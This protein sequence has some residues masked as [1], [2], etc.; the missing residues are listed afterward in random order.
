MSNTKKSVKN[1]VYSIIGQIVTITIGFILPRLWVVSY[2]SEVNGLLSSLSQFLVYLGL[3]EAGIG[4]A[5]LHA[6]YKPVAENDWSGIN[7]VLAAS[8][9]YYRQTGRLYFIGLILLSAIYPFVAKS[10]LPY[11]TVFGSVFF[12]GIGNVILFYFQGKYTCLLHAEGKNYIIVNLST[13]ITILNGITKV[14][15]IYLGMDIVVII[16]ST[17]LIQCIQA[18]YIMWYMRRYKKIN[19]R[20]EPNIHSVSQKKSILIHQ[21]STLVFQ[22]TDILILT[23]ACDLKIVSVYSLFKLITTQIQNILN[24][25]INSIRFA[26]GQTFQLNKA[27]FIKH[28]DI[29]E[30]L[31]SAML[32]GLFSVTLYLYLPFM[33]LYTAGVTD[34]NYI[35]PWLAL[36]FVVISLLDKS[37]TSMLST[38]EFAGHFKNTVRQTITESVINLTISLIGVYL[39][40]IYGVLIGT[41]VALSYRT[42]DIIIY[43]NHK[44]LNRS[45]KKTYL[46]YLINILSFLFLQ[47]L[48]NLY[49]SSNIT[50]YLNFFAVGIICSIIAII[51]SVG[52]QVAVFKDCRDIIKILPKKLLIILKRTGKTPCR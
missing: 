24:I 37:R 17:F 11:W 6:L 25:P 42:N 5:T 2:G 20:V 48:F 21:I 36:L 40:G 31:Y 41:I 15:L 7:S 23:L 13:L 27:Q 49:D 45:A 8:N 43:A 44:I 52:A 1:L 22:N 38:I 33:R 19:L 12:S 35:D 3:F 14:I 16:A 30:S 9:K 32:Y 34:I 50:S 39:W 29:V 51:L 26:L 28:I 10:T 18:I 4:A 46:I 47:F